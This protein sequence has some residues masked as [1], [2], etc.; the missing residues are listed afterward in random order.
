MIYIATLNTFLCC[1]MDLKRGKLDI[2]LFIP[3]IKV[4]AKYDLKGN[5]LLLPLVG[6]GDAR[7]YLS[8]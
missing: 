1:R 7:L 6:I 4:E 3:L 5:I 2:G 8:K